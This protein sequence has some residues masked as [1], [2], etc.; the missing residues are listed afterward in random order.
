[1]SHDPLNLLEFAAKSIAVF[2]DVS[3]LSNFCP[4]KLDVIP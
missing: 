4:V 2:P 3:H 1:M